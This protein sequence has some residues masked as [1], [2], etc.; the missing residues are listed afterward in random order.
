VVAGP[1][2]LRR[3][4]RGEDAE[5]LDSWF[6]GVTRFGLGARSYTNNITSID[7]INDTDAEHSFGIEPGAVD[8]SKIPEEVVPAYGLEQKLVEAS[9]PGMLDEIENRY[10]DGDDFF[11][12]AWSPH[13]M[14]QRYDFEYLDDPLDAFEEVVDEALLTT[15]VIEELPEYDPVAYAFLDALTFDEEQI[16]DLENTISETGDPLGGARRWAR[17][18]PDIVEPWLEAARAAQP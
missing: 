3:R 18:N 17:E 11:F 16:N 7:Q 14:N 6:G 1:R 4:D 12:I 15:V 9:T 2:R 5:L 10:D 13:W 8:M